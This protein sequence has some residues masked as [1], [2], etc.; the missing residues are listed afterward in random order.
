LKDLA[1][2][3]CKCAAGR[4]QLSEHATHADP[5]PCFVL[6][7]PEHLSCLRCSA[8]AAQGERFPESRG[9]APEAA[10]RRER[11]PHRWKLQ[12]AERLPLC[13]ARRKPC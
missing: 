12:Q 2:A 1:D 3:R 13:K 9:A 5:A 8:A 6:R 4:R 10:R 11:Q 7:A